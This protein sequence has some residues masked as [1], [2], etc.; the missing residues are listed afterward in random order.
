MNS[1][2]TKPESIRFGADSYELNIVKHGHG[3]D[4]TSYTVT[5]CEVSDFGDALRSTTKSYY[6][7]F[8]SRNAAFDFCQEVARGEVRLVKNDWV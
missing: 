1:I 3:A 7:T 2:Y 8:A 4:T 6:N 5:I